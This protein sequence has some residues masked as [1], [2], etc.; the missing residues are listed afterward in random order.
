MLIERI[1]SDLRLSVDF[2]DNLA[3]TASLRYRRYQI[4]KRSGGARTIDQPA[5]ELKSVQRWLASHIIS[6]FPVHG[7]ATA[8][9]P[10]AS[11]R[12]NASGHAR[13]HYSV[14]L[15]F[16]DFF[17][18]LTATDIEALCT[19]RHSL[20]PAGWSDNDSRFLT[21]ICCRNRRLTIGAPS[22]PALSNVLCHELDSRIHALASA[23]DV[24]YTRYADDIVLSCNAPNVLR[25]LCA[26]VHDALSTLPYPSGLQLNFRKTRHSSRKRRRVITG[27]TLTSDGRISIGREHKRILRARVHQAGRLSDSELRRLA[28]D[29]GHVKSIEPNVLTRLAT[30]Y[31]AQVIAAIK[32]GDGTQLRFLEAAGARRRA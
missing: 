31:G 30:R 32:T 25:P 4:P 14:R 5:R 12:R 10:G 6:V 9:A 17:R 8:Y 22:S 19:A 21:A 3:H 18:S 11:I 1:S 15:D 29:L 7:A 23:R 26:L 28:G 13:S 2:L 20:L 27:V 16:Q 24:T